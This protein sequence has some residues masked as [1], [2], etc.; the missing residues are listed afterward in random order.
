[1][2]ETIVASIASAAI[3]L[4]VMLLVV[5]KIRKHPENV[6]AEIDAE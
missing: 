5:L 3:T 6:Q 4:V 2:N 1:M